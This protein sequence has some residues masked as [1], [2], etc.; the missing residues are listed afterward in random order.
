MELLKV[1]GP[2]WINVQT[3]EL[4]LANAN[5]LDK[6]FTITRRGVVRYVGVYTTV[7]PVRV[8]LCKD[9]FVNTANMMF[10]YYVSNALFH[11]NVALKPDLFL[12]P[13]SYLFRLN[14]QSGGAINC[15][16]ILSIEF[17]E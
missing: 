17:I 15:N 16:I 10:N 6:T 8:Y 7:T 12:E 5:D 13:G 9:N 1:I 14:N 11:P 4:G 3:Y 2:P